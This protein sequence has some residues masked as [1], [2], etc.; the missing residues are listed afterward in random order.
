MVDLVTLT[1]LV[2]YLKPSKADPV[3]GESR[4]R[5]SFDGS[6]VRIGFGRRSGGCWIRD[7]DKTGLAQPDVPVSISNSTLRDIRQRYGYRIVAGLRNSSRP[8]RKPDE[9]SGRIDV[10]RTTRKC[11]SPRA[12]G[13]LNSFVACIVGFGM[14]E[15]SSNYVG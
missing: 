8:S 5:R 6:K 7:V 15:I 14:P 12:N 3:L 9:Q 10:P 11:V 2:R 1:K 13:R 4:E